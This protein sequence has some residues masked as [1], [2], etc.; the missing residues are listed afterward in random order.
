[1]PKLFDFIEQ[2]KKGDEFMGDIK[3]VGIDLAKSVFLFTVLISP[4]RQ[5]SK[6]SSQGLKCCN[7][8]LI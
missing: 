6:R 8:S 5:S 3:T 4:G 2:F 7:F 1:V